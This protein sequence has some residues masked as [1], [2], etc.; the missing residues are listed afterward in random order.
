MKVELS[1]DTH[2]FLT[3]TLEAADRKATW[4]LA[5]IPPQHKVLNTIMYQY[6][7]CRQIAI[8]RALQELQS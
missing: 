4:E 7:I 5:V 1:P 8:R 2:T 6:W 3:M